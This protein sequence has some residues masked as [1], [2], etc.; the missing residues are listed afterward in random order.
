[1]SPDPASQAPASQPRVPLPLR[2]LHMR[3]G[4]FWAAVL[5]ALYFFFVLE[6]YYMLRPV[7][8]AMGINGG[9]DKLPWLMTGT[10]VAMGAVNPL[11]A[12]LVSRYPR[13]VFIPTTYRVCAGIMVV[14]FVLFE[15]FPKQ[16]I[17]GLGYAFYIWLSVFNLFVV[18]V[19]WSLMVDVYT[20]EQGKRLFGVIAIGGT[21]GAIVGASVTGRLVTGIDVERFGL[22]PYLLKVPN[23]GILL[24]SIIPL[25]LAVWC[26][27]WLLGWQKRSRP[28]ERGGEGARC[29]ACAYDVSGLVPEEGMIRC[30]ECGKSHRVAV[31]IANEPSAGVWDG[32]LAICRSPYLILI[33]VFM[34]L[35]TITN[36]FVYMEQG[37]IVEQTIADKAQRTAAFANIDN[38][39]NY[40]TLGTQLLLTGQ[41]LRVLGVGGVLCILPAVTIGGFAALWANPTVG[42]VTWV[43]SVRRGL[44]YAMMRP[45]REILFTVLGQDERYKSKTFIDTFIFR[46]GDMIGGWTPLAVKAMGIAIGWLAIPLSVLWLVTGAIL[47]VLQARKA[48]RLKGPAPA[49]EQASAPA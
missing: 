39:A 1:M 4:E 22:G 40:L 13:R 29:P 6:S 37:R 33:A 2:V 9:Y 32:M 28:M 45:A 36:T 23:Q 17:T 21:V 27:R 8:E 12:W 41:A 25:E 44:H 34:L 48:E 3:P 19:F 26:V 14:F 11:F 5:S 42:V 18:S 7:R 43:M 24:L 38:W 49:T 47:G 20:R 35:L 30:P 46:A 15:V 16:W 31:A 10:M